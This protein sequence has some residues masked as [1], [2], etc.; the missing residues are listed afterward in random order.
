MRQRRA[1]FERFERAYLALWWVPAGSL[2]AVDE[3]KARLDHRTAHGPTPF[4]FDFKVLFPPEA[5]EP[6]SRVSTVPQISE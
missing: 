3:A 1:W 6:T 2:P 5:S 4:A